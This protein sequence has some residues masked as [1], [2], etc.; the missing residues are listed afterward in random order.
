ML[1]CV[2]CSRG[3][4]GR[5]CGCPGGPGDCTDREDADRASRRQPGTS[6]EVP[7]RCRAL[8]HAPTLARDVV[9]GPSIAAPITAHWNVRTRGLPGTEDPA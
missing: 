3:V 8:I 6:D 5:I 9:A 7:S 2:D 1:S 4:N